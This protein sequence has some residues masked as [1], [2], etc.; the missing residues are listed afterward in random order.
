MKTPT[1]IQ[2]TLRRIGWTLTVEFGS[3]GYLAELRA[4]DGSPVCCSSLCS[5]IE[6][7][8]RSLE[9]KIEALS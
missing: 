8:I 2:A 6:R 4:P 9:W 1:R 5:S 3:G 7:A